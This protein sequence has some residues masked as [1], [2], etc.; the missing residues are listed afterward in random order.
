VHFVDGTTNCFN[1][2]P[3]HRLNRLDLDDKSGQYSI[4]MSEMFGTL[5][6]AGLITR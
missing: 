4:S 6:R 1:L 5:E 2:M 3:S